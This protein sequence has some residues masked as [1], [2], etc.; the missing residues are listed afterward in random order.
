MGL[1][2][3]SQA[4]PRA[5]ILSR[6]RFL[7][8]SINEYSLVFHSVNLK[9]LSLQI[10]KYFHRKRRWPSEFSLVPLQKYFIK[11]LT[12]GPSSASCSLRKQGLN[13]FLSGSWASTMN[14][15]WLPPVLLWLQ[16]RLLQE[17]PWRWKPSPIHCPQE[18]HT[19]SQATLRHC[20]GSYFLA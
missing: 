10:I 13:R 2:L 14:F 19:V 18:W 11:V 9:P 12:P 17:S 6:Y 3:R 15:L 1:S 7:H 20:N 5:F 4:F 8:L 16:V